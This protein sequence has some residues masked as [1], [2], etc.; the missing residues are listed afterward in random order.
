MK[1]SH[2][3]LR[4]SQMTLMHQPLQP[5]KQLMATC[6]SSQ[7]YLLPTSDMSKH[8][9]LDRSRVNKREP[10]QL[11]LINKIA[12][13]CSSSKRNAECRSNRK[14]NL[15]ISVESETLYSHEDRKLVL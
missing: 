14:F 11:Q 4:C 5:P 6:N 7:H 1:L 9:Q 3:M 13:R 2:D 8:N 10:I 15:N 12:S